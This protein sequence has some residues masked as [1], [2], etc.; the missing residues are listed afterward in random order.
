MPRLTFLPA[1]A[2]IKAGDRVVTSGHGGV[3]PPGLQVGL[4]VPSSDGI[5]RV[6]PN[7]S[8]DQLEFVRLIDFASVSPVVPQGEPAVPPKKAAS[9]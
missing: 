5:M 3:F 6:K 4:I 2:S 9:R 8:F 1:N 7:V